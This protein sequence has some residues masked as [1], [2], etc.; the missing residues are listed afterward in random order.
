MLHLH[1]K[2]TPEQRQAA[3]HTYVL[4]TW[5]LCMGVIKF[6][7]ARCSCL[8]MPSPLSFWI[9]TRVDVDNYIV[10][11]QMLTPIWKLFA[12]PEG[13]KM[14]TFGGPHF[15]FSFK[16]D[17]TACPLPNGPQNGPQNHWMWVAI[18]IAFV[19]ASLDPNFNDVISKM[20]FIMVSQRMIFFWDFRLC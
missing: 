15:R 6:T 19:T 5:C 16:C 10:F 17:S 12:C 11:Y 18:F 20:I 13:V 3:K 7:E 4:W 8:P 2:V 9:S 1:V 14:T